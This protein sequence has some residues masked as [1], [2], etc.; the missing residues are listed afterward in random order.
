[1][2]SV[3]SS[4]SSGNATLY[5]FPS[6]RR[7]ALAILYLQNQDLSGKTPEELVDMYDEAW[8]KI[9]QEFK[10]ISDKKREERRKTRGYTSFLN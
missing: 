1:V 10:S 6:D 4:G 7:D 8:N 2:K 9:S 3:A 5:T